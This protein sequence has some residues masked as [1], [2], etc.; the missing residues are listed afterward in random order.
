M[1]RNNAT[2]P[3]LELAHLTEEELAKIRDVLKKQE[4][5]EKE[6]ERSIV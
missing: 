5:F 2:T 3:K 4:Q 1:A 6:I